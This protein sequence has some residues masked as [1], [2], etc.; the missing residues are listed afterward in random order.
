M[1]RFYSALRIVKLVVLRAGQSISHNGWLG[2]RKNSLCRRFGAK[3]RLHPLERVKRPISAAYFVAET[4][5]KVFLSRNVSRQPNDRL[6]NRR[7]LSLIH[8]ASGLGGEGAAGS[9]QPPRRKR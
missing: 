6:V 8:S 5:T 2:L 7:A 3:A 1:R 9:L 4:K